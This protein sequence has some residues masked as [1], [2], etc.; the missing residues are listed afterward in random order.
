MHR[1]SISDISISEVLYFQINKCRSSYFIIK[2]ILINKVLWKYISL[3][4]FLTCRIREN[5]MIWNKE[6]Q[7]SNFGFAHFQFSTMRIPNIVR[8][9]IINYACA[10]FQSLI[11]G[12]QNIICPMF[13][14]K[15]HHMVR[16]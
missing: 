9:Q 2:Y 7:Y 14:I 10:D 6:H 12:I 5:T 4:R 1:F 3:I 15:K 11:F 16:F 8:V 13:C